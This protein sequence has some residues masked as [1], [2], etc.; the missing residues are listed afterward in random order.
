MGR[1]SRAKQVRREL[2]ARGDTDVLVSEYFRAKEALKEGRGIVLFC[3][4]PVSEESLPG[5]LFAEAE[6]RGISKRAMMVAL[7]L[8]VDP[9]DF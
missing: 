3:G 9:E 4:Q 6:T 5:A 1:K 2:S 8:S 7:M